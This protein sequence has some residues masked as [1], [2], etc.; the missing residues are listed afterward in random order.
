[1]FEKRVEGRR[2]RPAGSRQVDGVTEHG[3]GFGGDGCDGYTTRGRGMTWG[4]KGFLFF[5]FF[6]P[7]A[8]LGMSN[9]Y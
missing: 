3:G 9:G 1:M 2:E 7:P 5:L 6:D 4:G 8:Y